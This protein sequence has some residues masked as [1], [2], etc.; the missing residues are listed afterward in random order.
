MGTHI[1]C[2]G[3]IYSVETGAHRAYA[4]LHSPLILLHRELV[5]QSL[6]SRLLSGSPQHF[7][8]SLAAVWNKLDRLQT[9]AGQSQTAD[10]PEIGEEKPLDIS[11]C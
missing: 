3:V 1:L 5:A 2:S 9:S 6:N 8:Q 7:D 10:R 4:S 11:A